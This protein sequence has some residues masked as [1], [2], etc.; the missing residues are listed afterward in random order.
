M[1]VGSSRSSSRVLHISHPVSNR[2]LFGTKKR[3]VWISSS[4]W[5]WPM[6]WKLKW[7]NVSPWIFPSKST[8]QKTEKKRVLVTTSNVSMCLMYI[9]YIIC[10]FGLAGAWV[11][12]EKKKTRTFTE[13][14]TSNDRSNSRNFSPTASMAF[15]ESCFYPRVDG[16]LC[17]LEK[18]MFQ[19]VFETWRTK[20][21]VR[22]CKAA[23]KTCI[24]FWG[25]DVRIVVDE[26]SLKTILQLLS[27]KKS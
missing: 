26:S 12:R 14:F 2:H 15:D 27:L 22:W 7:K 16:V 1:A 4:Y 19:Q 10:C 6:N 21:D 8:K 20:T 25:V 23:I 11:F 13:L 18:H 24:I 3:M 5:A 17:P 9:T